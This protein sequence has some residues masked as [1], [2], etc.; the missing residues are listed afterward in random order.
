MF[1]FNR[2]LFPEISAPASGVWSPAGR[3][4]RH[5]CGQQ[6]ATRGHVVVVDI[7]C[8]ALEAANLLVRGECASVRHYFA[9]VPMCLVQKCSQR[10]GGHRQ[11]SHS[12]AT[13][14]RL[15]SSAVPTHVSYLLPLHLSALPPALLSA[16]SNMSLNRARKRRL[17]ARSQ[18][19]PTPP[20]IPIHY[21]VLFTFL[22][23]FSS[24]LL[25]VQS[26]N[27]EWI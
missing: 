15:R 13:C 19:A 18:H 26:W 7:W 5:P 3:R 2:H 17:S 14:G 8:P 10:G 23:F 21:L 11:V 9:I 6:D 27:P 16:C 20:P 22:A 4:C 12:L 25:F 1:S 24:F